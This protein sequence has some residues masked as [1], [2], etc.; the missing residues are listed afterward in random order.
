MLYHHYNW[1]NE[2]GALHLFEAF[3]HVR[4]LGGS[5]VWA[6]DAG[7]REAFGEDWRRVRQSILG[8]SDEVTCERR[9]I[10]VARNYR[11]D[12]LGTKEMRELLDENVQAVPGSSR[13]A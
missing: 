10:V 3:D 8:S 9:P 11:R 1:R 7:L 12:L 13:A 4:A 6:T 5:V 2:D